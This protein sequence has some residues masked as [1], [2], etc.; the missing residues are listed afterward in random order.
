MDCVGSRWLI[1]S[2]FRPPAACFRNARE[3]SIPFL[4][5]TASLF[6]SLF[7]GRTAFPGPGLSETDAALRGQFGFHFGKNALAY[8]FQS[9]PASLLDPQAQESFF[10]GTQK[11]L[12]GLPEVDLAFHIV[13]THAVNLDTAL[14]DEPFGLAARGCKRQLH[15]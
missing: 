6:G 5:T 4:G 1:C 11:I 7:V 8:S 3:D 12:A 9:K 14:F 10:A 13:H 15:E 2:C